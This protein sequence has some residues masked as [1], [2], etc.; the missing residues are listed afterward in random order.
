MTVTVR[1]LGLAPTSQP[2]P[3]RILLGEMP[4]VSTTMPAGIEF[5]GTFVVTGTWRAISDV[6]QLTAQVLPP[7]SEDLDGTNDQVIF[8]VGVPP[9]PSGLV[10][11]RNLSDLSLGLAWLPVNAPTLAGYRIY[12]TEGSGQV[13]LIGLSTQTGFADEDIRPGARYTYTVS[14]ITV[15][16]VESMPSVGAS[17]TAPN[18]VYLPVIL[19]K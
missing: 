18:A 13:T 12:R 15:D 11:S 4:I 9:Q 3:V 5:N 2:M 16:G 8:T 7:L 1:N 17:I 6:Q 10:A 14:S 19:R